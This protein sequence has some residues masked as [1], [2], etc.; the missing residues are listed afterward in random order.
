MR[1]VIGELRASLLSPEL[2]QSRS[3]QE[4]L[5]RFQKDLDDTLLDL[6]GDPRSTN[7]G[8]TKVQAEKGLAVATQAREALRAKAGVPADRVEQFFQ[9]KVQAQ[10]Y[11][12]EAQLIANHAAIK[13]GE[14]L[15][16]HAKSVAAHHKADWFDLGELG[17]E[18]ALV[19]SSVAILSRRSGYW[20]AGILLCV[21]GLVAV[22]KGFLTH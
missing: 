21:L 4:L 19:L 16:A 11:K 8:T 1:E 7:P 10:R 3:E 9:A 2:G 12:A 15:I 13:H 5:T 18:L 17:V 6:Q 14:A 22:A 20:H